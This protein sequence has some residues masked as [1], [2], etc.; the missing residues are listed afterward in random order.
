MLD[1]DEGV[2]S[3]YKSMEYGEQLDDVVAVKADV[4]FIKEIEGLARFLQSARQQQLA[5]AGNG[6]LVLRGRGRR[7]PPIIFC[8]KPLSASCVASLRF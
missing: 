5:V 2:A 6:P 1:E 4:G 7:A 3:V 8:Y